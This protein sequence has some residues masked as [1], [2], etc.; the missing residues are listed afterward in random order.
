LK[1]LND[2]AFFCSRRISIYSFTIARN[3]NDGNRNPGWTYDT[4]GVKPSWQN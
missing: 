2:Q 3:K 4:I 1:E